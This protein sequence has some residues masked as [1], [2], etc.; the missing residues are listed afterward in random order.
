MAGGTPHVDVFA[1]RL[2]DSTLG[3]FLAP[4][5]RNWSMANEMDGRC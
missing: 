3:L 5:D 4:R 1:A 2:G